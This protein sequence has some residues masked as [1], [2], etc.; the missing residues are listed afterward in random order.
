MYRYSVHITALNDKEGGEL[1]RFTKLT[2]ATERS[3]KV[4]IN[5]K[6]NTDNGTLTAQQLTKQHRHVLTN[7]NIINRQFSRSEH[8]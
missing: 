6:S 2:L 4:T 5:S 7:C 1:V 8:E 3:L